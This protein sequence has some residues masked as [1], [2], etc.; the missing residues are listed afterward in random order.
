MTTG[1]NHLTYKN[2]NHCKDINYGKN[3][4]DPIAKVYSIQNP[5][6]KRICVI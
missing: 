2:N 6:G 5:L 3:D 4:G 1:N